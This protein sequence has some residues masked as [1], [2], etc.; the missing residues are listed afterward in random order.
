VTTFI[1]PVK[2]TSCSLHFSVY[3]N[4][5]DWQAQYCPE[6][7]QIGSFIQ[8][9]PTESPIPIYE[10]VP[11]AGEKIPS[12]VGFTLLGDEEPPGRAR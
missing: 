7:G 12:R 1:Y 3:S 8:W 4:F 9:P 5:E 10:Y 6:C 11:G 2:C